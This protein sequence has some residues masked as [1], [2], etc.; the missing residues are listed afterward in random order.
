MAGSDDGSI[1]FWERESTN[2][3][4]ILKGDSSIVNCLQPHPSSCLLASSG[5]DTTVR[6]WS[7]QP[8]VKSL[9]FI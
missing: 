5:I 1:Y 4:R 3:V 7:P 8:E 9:S 2:N 6:L